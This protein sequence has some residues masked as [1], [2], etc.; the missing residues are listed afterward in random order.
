MKQIPT[1]DFRQS[2]QGSKNIQ[3]VTK[4]NTIWIDDV[5]IFLDHPIKKVNKM[6]RNYISYSSSCGYLMTIF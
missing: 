4:V 1:K 3:K 5:S 6:A 2:K